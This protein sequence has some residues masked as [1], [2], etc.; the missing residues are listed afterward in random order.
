MQPFLSLD[1]KVTVALIGAAIVAV[2]WFVNAWRDRQAERRARKE[3]VRDVQ[4]A[5]A[6]EILPYLEA[7]EMFDL[8]QHLDEMIDRM[9]SDP[10]Y[11]PVVPSERNDTVFRAILPNIH[12][13]PE[14]VIRPV[15]RYYSQ[16][17]AIEAIIEDLRSDAFHAMQVEQ[18]EAI[19]ADYISMKI[20]ALE[21]GRNAVAAIETELRAGK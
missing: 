14:T 8:D 6:A 19:Y 12:V 9:R 20:Q 21:Q 17:F 3:R 10:G 15:V 4:T 13:L 18:R 1:V 5:L 7:L 2:G 16:V 11:V